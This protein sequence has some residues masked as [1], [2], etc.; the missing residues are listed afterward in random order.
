VPLPDDPARDASLLDA[1]DKALALFDEVVARQM[2]RSGR[3]ERELSDDIRDLAAEMFGIGRYWHKRV[4]RAGPHT[5]E[6]Y[7]ANPPDR[8]IDA[9][10]I[11]FLDF[12][13]I[14]EQWE[15]DI[16]RTFVLGQDPAK[17]RLADALPEIWAEGK[18][19]FDTTAD[20]TGAQLF[21][22]VLDTIGAAGWGHG[23]SH[24]GHLVGEFPHEKINGDDIDSYITHGSEQPMR[25]LDAAGKPCRWIL[26]VH[27]VDP[28]GEFGG[29]H[30]Q[31]LNI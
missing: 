18:Q 13:P 25:R 19:H 30:E 28:T 24:A 22:H 10:D 5:L 23:A 12:G 8:T 27:L 29:F 20:I 4:V 3:G 7:R 17:L 1:Q 11:V 6:P 15:A 14:F 26:E 21:A 16:G 31:L 9:D 2:I